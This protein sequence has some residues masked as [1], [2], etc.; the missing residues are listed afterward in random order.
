MYS[1]QNKIVAITGA[2]SGIGQALAIEAM[3]RGAKIAVCARNI[4]K[5]KQAIGV[6][7]P[8]KVLYI[9]A[10]VSKEADCELF[11]NAAINKWLRIDVLINNAGIS[12]RALFEDADLSVIREL[13]DI[14]FWGTVYC[15]KYAVKSIRENKGTVVGVSSIA[16]YR[17][18]PARTGYSASKFA[19]QGFMEALRTELLSTGAN[20]MWVSPGF[21]ASNIRNVAR[22]ADGSAQA[23]TPLDESKL[24]TAE[25]CAKIIC[26]SIQKRKRTVIMTGQG[27]LTVLINKLFPRLA[28]KLVFNHFL[29]EPNSPLQKYKAS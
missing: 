16:G 17:G 21:T 19:M 9:Q 26:D 11:I 15:T 23:E 13:M 20:V 27:K 1:L 24:M 5:L 4:E 3:H 14:N 2:S 7:D 6:D 22:S 29:T 10:D 12:M 25:E 18:L 28:D 8:E